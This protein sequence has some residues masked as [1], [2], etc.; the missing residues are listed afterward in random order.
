VA[1]VCIK[2]K[3][4]I[5]FKKKVASL[6]EKYKEYLKGKEIKCRSIRMSNPKN[7]TSKFSPEYYF[8]KYNN[9]Q[10]LYDNFC[11]ELEK[12]LIDTEFTIISVSVNKENKKSTYPSH[13]TLL[14]VIGDLFERIFIYHYI[15]KIK[16]SSL[17]FDSTGRIDDKVIKESYEKFLQYGS[18][19]IGKEKMAGI[20]LRKEIYPLNSESCMGIQLADLCA[21]PIK[22]HVEK[23]GE[24][25]DFFKKVIVKKL[26]NDVR[27]EITKKTIKMGIKVSLRKR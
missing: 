17:I 2:Q 26:C 22:R 25:S 13:N 15:K 8:W 11:E 19:F 27:D 12:I 18:W 6:K 21:Y 16:S 4:Y 10:K 14:T 9:G 20:P 1:A 24:N 23:P 3:N 7:V 5:T